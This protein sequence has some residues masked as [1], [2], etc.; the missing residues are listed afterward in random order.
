MAAAL[1]ASLM[2]VQRCSLHHGW[3]A[4][5]LFAICAL[6]CARWGSCKIMAKALIIGG[7]LGGL[8]AGIELHHAGCDVEIFER[9]HR[10]LDDRG[11][12]IVMQTETL[13]MLTQRCGLAEDET[14]VWLHQ[15]QDWV[16][17]GSRN[18]SKTCRN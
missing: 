7:S 8:M 3:T 17:M 2:P 18:R 6:I 15:R 4:R 16:A 10:V 14:G 11:A 13:R 9:S 5:G 1:F 12:G